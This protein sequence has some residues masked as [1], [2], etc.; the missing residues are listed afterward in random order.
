MSNADVSGPERARACLVAFVADGSYNGSYS[1]RWHKYELFTRRW[2]V[3]AFH[4][5]RAMEWTKPDFTVVAVTM[6]V[7]AYAATK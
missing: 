5:E 2:R 7:T 6:E 3:D 4:E 1:P